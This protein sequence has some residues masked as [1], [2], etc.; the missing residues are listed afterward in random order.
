MGLFSKILKKEKNV[1]DQYYNKA[2]KELKF[3]D[4]TIQSIFHNFSFIYHY[5]IIIY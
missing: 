2:E 3:T 1:W 4:K 5:I